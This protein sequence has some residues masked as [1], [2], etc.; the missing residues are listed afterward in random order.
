MVR[1]V[2]GE[3]SGTGIGLNTGALGRYASSVG[4]LRFALGP[5]DGLPTVIKFEALPASR[6]EASLRH[7]C[8]AKT[9]RAEPQG[10]RASH[11]VLLWVLIATKVPNVSNGKAPR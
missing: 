10:F 8:R 4:L 3:H 7:R 2:G 9:S 11:W 1:E 5:P 6:T